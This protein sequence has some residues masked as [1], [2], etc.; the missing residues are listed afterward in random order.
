MKYLYDSAVACYVFPNCPAFD[1]VFPIFNKG[2]Y[3]PAL[4][5]VKCWDAIGTS[6]ME[7][8]LS[9][10]KQYM[11]WNRDENKGDAKALCILVVIG[12]QEVGTKPI[13]EGRFP[14]EDAFVTIVVPKNDKFGVTDVIVKSAT[15][16]ARAEALASHSFAH[17]EDRDYNALR[18]SAR[19]PDRLF[20][21][22]LIDDQQRGSVLG[23]RE[24]TEPAPHG[25]EE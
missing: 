2:Q 11:E 6:D 5:S 24:E 18:A 22:S 12:S 23:V 15:A 21:W 19:G 17:V 20:G 10:M 14:E 1:L 7:G 4:V 13:D 25:M 8:A 9:D 16:S 3:H